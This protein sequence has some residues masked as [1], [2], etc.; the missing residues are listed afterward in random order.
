MRMSDNVVPRLE[1]LNAAPD[2]SGS[3][4]IGNER[5]IYRNGVLKFG[6]ETYAVSDDQDFVI[7]SKRVPIG[8]I[9][10]GRLVS[11]Q[12]LGPL[13]LQFYKRKYQI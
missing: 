7:S 8:A 13:Q 2:V 10:N 4:I 9:I 5:F 11:I 6:G 12:Q 3:V 1:G